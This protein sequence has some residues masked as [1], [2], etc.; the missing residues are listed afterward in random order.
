MFLSNFFQETREKRI[1]AAKVEGIAEEEAKFYRKMVE[2]ECHRKVAEVTGA[3]RRIK[4]SPYFVKL[5]WRLS[6]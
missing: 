1:Q 3:I 6:H 5:N 2:W 4:L